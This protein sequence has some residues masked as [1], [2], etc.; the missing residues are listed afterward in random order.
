MF[1]PLT[2]VMSLRSEPYLNPVPS[3]HP[4]QVNTM[5]VLGSRYKHILHTPHAQHSNHPPH[6]PSTEAAAAAAAAV[7]RYVSN[8][9]RSQLTSASAQIYPFS[10]RE[11]AASS[12]EDVPCHKHFR[13]KKPKTSP[14]SRSAKSSSFLID[15]ILGKSITTP[16]RLSP[17]QTISRTSTPGQSSQH[18][19]GGHAKSSHSLPPHLAPPSE[20]TTPYGS[21]LSGIGLPFTQFAPFQAADSLHHP[22]SLRSNSSTTY[23]S[24]YETSQFSTACV[25]PSPPAY[26]IGHPTLT[27]SMLSYPPIG[28]FG[29]F[30]HM[31]FTNQPEFFF[32]RDLGYIK[33]E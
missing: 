22:T 23:K 27:G 10:N 3:S 5:M 24:L 9:G 15:D 11:A 33:G 29:H 28:N 20:P 7:Q 16:E 26:I 32:D 31:P 6:P 19:D 21:P 25:P 30:S 4:G 12:L 14:S 1:L 2:S 18:S 8:S 13:H 17:E